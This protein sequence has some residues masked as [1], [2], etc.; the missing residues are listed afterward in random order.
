[1][2]QQISLYGGPWHGQSASLQDAVDYFYI[3]EMLP[4]QQMPDGT[5]PESTETIP[6]RR[7]GYSRVRDT[8]DFEWDGWRP[9]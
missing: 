8:A 9:K 6:N 1:M 3:Q 2:A 5:I 7:G 4:V